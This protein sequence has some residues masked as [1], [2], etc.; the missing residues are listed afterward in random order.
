MDF[1]ISSIPTDTGNK[2]QQQG[3][4]YTSAEH[5]IIS[6]FKDE[7]LSKRTPEEREQVI[8][9]KVVV[10]IFKYWLGRE[11]V[12]PSERETKRRINVSSFPLRSMNVFTIADN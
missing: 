3:C 1:S 12:E 4:K 9:G 5:A 11:G 8:K 10:D 2:K 7:Y 6:R